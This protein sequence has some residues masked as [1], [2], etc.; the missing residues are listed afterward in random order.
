MAYKDK[1]G[2]TVAT[3]GAHELTPENSACSYYTVQRE[4]DLDLAYRHGLL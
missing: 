4:M 3:V 1:D 2:Q